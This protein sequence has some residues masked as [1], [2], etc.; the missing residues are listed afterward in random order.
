MKAFLSFLILFFVFNSIHLYSQKEYHETQQ[1]KKEKLQEDYQI[2]REIVEEVHP[3]LFLYQSPEK[4]CKIF[5]DYNSKINR[6]LTELEFYKLIVPI[7]DSIRC[8]H[9]FAELSP[10][11]YNYLYSKPLI[12]F[13][14]EILDN[15]IFV[16]KNWLNGTDLKP[17]TEILSINDYTS[18]QIIDSI[19]PSISADGYQRS[20]KLYRM[21]LHFRLHFAKYFGQTNQLIITLIQPGQPKPEVFIVSGISW[22][23]I[24]Q[25]DT[26]PTPKPLQFEII[27][28][29]NTGILTI[30]S[31]TM[32]YIH[33][34][35]M[36]YET[37]YKDAFSQI[38]SKNI[39][40]L[41]IDVR[42]N[43]GGNPEVFI[44]LL[45]YLMDKPFD[46]F[47]KNVLKTQEFPKILFKYSDLPRK[48][49]KKWLSTFTEYQ[50]GEIIVKPTDKF[51]ATLTHQPQDKA[52]TGDLYLLTDAGSYSAASVVPS[53][54]KSNRKVIMF[55]EETGGTASGNTSGI[56]PTVTL[57]YS[58]LR[59][60]VPLA[61]GYINASGYLMGRG[62]SPNYVVLRS[63]NDIIH[64]RDSQLEFLLNHIQTLKVK[65]TKQ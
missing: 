21:A 30:R 20:Y 65:P 13:D 7:L 44:P 53:F 5:D 54:L 55:G 39:K 18:K 9:T 59:I 17:G 42:G 37:F 23:E 14:V 45:K 50:N 15:R 51:I 33:L 19:S 26:L 63:P 49:N 35:G 2:L 56:T 16:K 1:I 48:Y 46:V 62:V 3:G 22:N 31:F 10:E 43:D 6:D 8:G 32:G 36:K 58:K 52:F 25:Q 40:N 29:L 61:S 57:P 38:S 24:K 60:N 64:N 4:M 12:P 47:R 27:D 41:V 11:F 34:F 28:S